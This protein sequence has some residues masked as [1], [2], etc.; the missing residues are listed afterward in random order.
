MKA[1]IKNGIMYLDEPIIDTENDYSIDS[2]DLSKIASE[3][4]AV[5]NV[6]EGLLLEKTFTPFKTDN[7]N[8]IVMKFGLKYDSDN[9]N[10]LFITGTVT[11]KDKTIFSDNYELDSYELIEE[12][13]NALKNN[14][15]KNVSIS[16]LNIIT[17]GINIIKEN[18]YSKA[19]DENILLSNELFNYKIE[20]FRAGTNHMIGVANR[21]LIQN[22]IM[23]LFEV[24]LFNAED[25]L[26]NTDI[27]VIINENEAIIFKNLKINSNNGK[28][29]KYCSFD[30][31]NTKIAKKNPSKEENYNAEK[32]KL[33]GLKLPNK[34]MS[35]SYLIE[36]L[37]KNNEQ[38][39]LIKCCKRNKRMN[40]VKI[41]INKYL[42][43]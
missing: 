5:D 34:D 19:F 43:S 20:I 21:L 35:T 8:D 41:N 24:I 29:I 7:N 14:K 22:E 38:E 23:V 33:K 9:D 36:E 15:N 17:K 11:K 1:T 31:N 37:L 6:M 10:K 18:L 30:L 2:V 25:S 32:L 26:D 13:L 3:T 16:S 4:I 42:L 39:T 28:S 12:I 40:I 27:K